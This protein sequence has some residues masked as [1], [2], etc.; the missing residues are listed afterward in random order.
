MHERH[1]SPSAGRTEATSQQ[2]PS[3]AHALLRHQAAAAD[4]PAERRNHI[5]AASTLHSQPPDPSTGVQRTAGG[6][7]WQPSH[8]RFGS[9]R[10]H[11]LGDTHSAEVR[12]ASGTDRPAVP[13]PAGLP[14]LP[15][16]VVLAIALAALVAEGRSVSAWARLSLV[17]RTWQ[18][19]MKGAT[20]LPARSG[21]VARVRGS[22]NV[23]EWQAGPIAEQHAARPCML[24]HE[25]P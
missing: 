12:S 9:E 22:T 7:G 6:H 4:V 25:V 15:R 20:V 5:T 1:G 10:S 14:P 21:V 24:E 13:L 18:R 2:H 3:T 19:E 11:E 17:C 16:D 23:T 8:A